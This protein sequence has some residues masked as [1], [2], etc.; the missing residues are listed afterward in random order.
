[1]KS[2]F[3]IG[4]IALFAFAMTG[5]QAQ[6]PQPTSTTQTQKIAF[7]DVEV[8]I[9]NMPE[10]KKAESDYLQH[11]EILQKQFEGEQAKLEQYYSTVMQKVQAGLLT[12][13]QQKAEEAKLMKMQEDLM[14]KKMELEKPVYDKF[15]DALKAVATA[16]KYTYIFDKKVFLFN[17][18]GDDAT[19]KVKAQLGVE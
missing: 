3:K 1:M 2:I 6:S 9:P 14:A 11:Q 19:S 4:I 18:G 5:C 15:N 7:V 17:E 12:P 8:I 10:Y 16:N 13:V